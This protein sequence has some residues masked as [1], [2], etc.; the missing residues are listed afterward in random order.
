MRKRMLA[1]VLAMATVVCLAGV[2]KADAYVNFSIGIPFPGVYVGPPAYPPA[3]YYPPAPVYYGP[4]AYYGGHYG[5]GP[6]YG[7]GPGYGGVVVL[8]GSAATMAAD[9]ATD[10]GPRWGG[11]RQW[12]GRLIG[13]YSAR[14]GTV[15]HHIARLAPFH[16]LDEDPTEAIHRDLDL[17]THLD[18]L[19]YEEAWIGEHHSAG[20]ESHLLAGALHRRRG[21]AHQAHSVGHGRRV[22]AVPP[23]PHGRESHPATRSDAHIPRYLIDYGS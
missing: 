13:T 19:G 4:P 1:A 22:A 10:G 16:P 15:P 6:A 8:G 21:R 23:P 14:P 11:G 12:G 7:Y 20:F 2:S 18:A 17:I 9:T 5:Y 3:Y